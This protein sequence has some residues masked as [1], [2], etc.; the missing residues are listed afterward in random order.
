VAG[1]RY[2]ERGEGKK[3]FIYIIKIVTILKVVQPP[4]WAR[5]R[6]AM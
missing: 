6:K 3:N 5:D 1:W 2:D 4:L